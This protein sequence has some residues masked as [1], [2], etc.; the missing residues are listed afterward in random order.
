MLTSWRVVNPEKCEQYFILCLSLETTLKA[1]CVFGMTCSAIIMMTG[2]GIIS[3]LQGIIGVMYFLEGFWAVVK[4][5]A[6]MLFRTVVF[7]IVFGC[8][9]IFVTVMNYITRQQ[10]CATA[11]ASEM[12]ECINLSKLTSYLQLCFAIINL[13][14][15]TICAM[16]LYRK[17]KTQQQTASRAQPQGKAKKQ[18]AYSELS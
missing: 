11:Q 9:G 12:D 5:D 3:I 15:T 10:Y 4:E 6:D 16:F 2:R 18:D 8:V 14:V 1:L 13:G 7:L 17:I